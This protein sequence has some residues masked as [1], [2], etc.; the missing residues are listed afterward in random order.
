MATK[1]LLFPYGLFSIKDGSEIRFREDKWLGDAKLHEQYPALY[2]IVRHKSDTLTKV[3][4]TSPPNVMFK[5]LQHLVLVQLT[6]GADEFRWNLYGNGKFPVDS[7]FL[8]TK[9]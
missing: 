1:K 8:C 7:I 3:M 9:L 6:L 5:L 4:E 2:N